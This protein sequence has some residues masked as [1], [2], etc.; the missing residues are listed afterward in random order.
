MENLTNL[1]DPTTF[2]TV[3]RY[4]NS[5]RSPITT[6]MLVRYRDALPRVASALIAE[7]G[8]T[9]EL[10]R[11]QWTQW[12][13]SGEVRLGGIPSGERFEVDIDHI[14][15]QAVCDV[16]YLPPVYLV[17]LR[18]YKPPLARGLAA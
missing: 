11:R 18:G 13:G 3:R 6:L 9:P 17:C 4:L 16:L 10:R 5:A 7:D 15:D 1:I 8:R 12:F 2:G 14:P